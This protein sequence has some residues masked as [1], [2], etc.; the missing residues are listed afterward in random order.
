MWISPYHLVDPLCEAPVG[1]TDTEIAATKSHHKTWVELGNTGGFLEPTVLLSN[2]ASVKLARRI[3]VEN[4]PCQEDPCGEHPMPC[5]EPPS[6]LLQG[7]HTLMDRPWE[8]YQGFSVPGEEERS[9]V[10]GRMFMFKHFHVITGKRGSL[11]SAECIP[12]GSGIGRG[13]GDL[14]TKHGKWPIQKGPTLTKR[15]VESLQLN[16]P[17]AKKLPKKLQ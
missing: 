11:E 13:V 8:P 6:H 3:H 9:S 16:L 5:M 10:L 12:S 4:I 17:E 2:C 1:P 15:Q 14:H 7:L